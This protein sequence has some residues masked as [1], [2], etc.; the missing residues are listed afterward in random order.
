MH[1]STLYIVE[2]SRENTPSIPDISSSHPTIE[3]EISAY[4]YYSYELIISQGKHNIHT[5]S[6][7]LSNQDTEWIIFYFFYKYYSNI[8]ILPRFSF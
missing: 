5:Y 6:R 1:N 2:A 3:E 4:M 7:H 8:V